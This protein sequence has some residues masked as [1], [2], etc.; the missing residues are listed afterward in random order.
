MK[1]C[2]YVYGDEDRFTHLLL[3]GWKPGNKMFQGS[4]G[5]DFGGASGTQF[6]AGGGFVPR[7]ALHIQPQH[8]AFLGRFTSQSVEP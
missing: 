8:P 4:Y 3:V 7:Q 2:K 1:A 5:N 6:G